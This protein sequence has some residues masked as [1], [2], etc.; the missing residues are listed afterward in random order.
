MSISK[1]EKDTVIKEFSLHDKDTGSTEVQ[2]AILTH[3]IRVLTDHFKSHKHD[4]QSRR[5][6]LTL[7]GRRRSLLNYLKKK[8]QD[9]Y[10]DVIKKLEL[11][12]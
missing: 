9:K 11:R 7:V 4:H 6:L 8:D 12:K 1:E 10:K 5:G 3:R 2:I